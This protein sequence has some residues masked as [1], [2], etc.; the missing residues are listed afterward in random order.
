V[1][2]GRSLFIESNIELDGAIELVLGSILSKHIPLVKD[3]EEP[4]TIKPNLVCFVLK[5]DLPT[6]HLVLRPRSF[7]ESVVGCT[8][9]TGTDETVPTLSRTIGRDRY[10]VFPF[11]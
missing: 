11:A 3:L 4:Q 2:S 9:S 1:K 7:S 6:S 5:S 10:A 8:V